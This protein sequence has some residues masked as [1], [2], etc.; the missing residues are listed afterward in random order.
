MPT[1]P[2]L[3]AVLDDIDALLDAIEKETMDFPPCKPTSADSYLPP[4]MRTRIAPLLARLREA[5]A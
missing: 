3:A 4:A 5:R 1:E 2:H